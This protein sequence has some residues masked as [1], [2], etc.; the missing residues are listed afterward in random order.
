M[1]IISKIGKKINEISP[2]I[3]QILQAIVGLNLRLLL[4]PIKFQFSNIYNNNLWGSQESV[5]GRGSILE[6]TEEIRKKIPTILDEYDINS[7]L[8]VPCG[9]FNWMKHVDLKNIN[10][11]GGDIVPDIIKKNKV[12]YE[13]PNKIFR[14]IDITTDEL[15]R[16]DL[17][18][19]RDC[20]V[21]LSYKDIFSAL[22][23]IK[24]SGS[25]YLLTTSFINR[26][27]NKNIFTGGWRPINLRIEPFKFPKPK[28][29]ID[30]KS[31]E[32]EGKFRDKH[33]G[34]WEINEIKI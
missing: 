34:L 26:M 11:I 29:I 10:Y 33:L 13:A 27:R 15:P 19:C 22:Q 6:E 4:K 20:F 30:E 32:A 21:H 5:S 17:V 18:L 16:A 25:K 24:K 23:N 7:L 9:D 28:K 8:D 2:K 31:K 12:K 14:I 1:N 3:V